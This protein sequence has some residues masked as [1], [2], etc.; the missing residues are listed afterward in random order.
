LT[1][2]KAYLIGDN[3][4]DDFRKDFDYYY[5]KV[6]FANA[7]LFYSQKGF[8]KY[9][10]NTQPFLKFESEGGTIVESGLY[11]VIID[12]N[13]TTGTGTSMSS[14]F[15][16]S[17]PSAQIKVNLKKISDPAIRNPLYY[18][19]FNGDVG[20]GRVDEDGVEA[21]KGYGIAFSGDKIKINNSENNQT[22]STT[23]QI[24]LTTIQQK[25]FEKTNIQNRGVLLK[26]TKDKIE[27]APT[28]P[29]PVLAKITAKDMRAEVYYSIKKT[30]ETLNA[31]DNLTYW[32]GIS[33][34]DCKDFLGNALFYRKQDA[35][36]DETN[37]TLK[38]KRQQESYGF[39]W[40]GTPK[41]KDNSS[42]YMQT[43]FFTPIGQSFSLENSC[44]ETPTQFY[45]PNTTTPTKTIS[46]S[47]APGNFE[48]MQ[49]TLDL[50]SERKACI[51]VLNGEM[52]LWWNNEEIIKA[53]DNVKK[54]MPINNCTQ[55]T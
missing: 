51:S 37:C 2:F 50:I 43:I 31:T 22:D 28:N 27:F 15:E 52:K 42:L 32:T 55:K 18:L 24:K 53:L 14:L 40:A 26:I 4:N 46:L 33:S 29:T 48:S 11:G 34:P 1:N 10:N 13:S 41:Q 39:E 21:R 25:S 47:H 19:P 35:R 38:N 3:Y 12:I 54:T 9:I 45:G 30:G 36:A 20:K 8:D 17:A 16:N 5:T 44:P 49:E 6:G 7:D 23:G